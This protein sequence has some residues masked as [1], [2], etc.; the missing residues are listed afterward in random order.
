LHFPLREAP[1]ADDEIAAV[2]GADPRLCFVFHPTDTGILVTARNFAIDE[3]TIV[4]VTVEADFIEARAW[5]D[6]TNAWDL[7]DRIALDNTN[8]LLAGGNGCIHGLVSGVQTPTQA[9][10][11]TV[12]SAC[13]GAPQVLQFEPDGNFTDPL[14][15]FT[16]LDNAGATLWI[17]NHQMSGE[18]KYSHIEIFP[19]GLIRTFL[20]TQID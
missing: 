19:G 2:V 18:T 14:D 20:D 10:V 17:G 4:Q 9:V 15:T 7:I 5:E 16:S 13:S 8:A 12:P 6:D 3:Q 1:P 11:S